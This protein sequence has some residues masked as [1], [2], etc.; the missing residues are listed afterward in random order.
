MRTEYSLTILSSPPVPISAV[1]AVIT[2]PPKV[3]NSL[4]QPRIGITVRENNDVSN[5]E[6]RYDGCDDD[7]GS[8][9]ICCATRP[10]FDTPKEHV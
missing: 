5:S 1:L 8:T 10:T 7:G 6:K 4:N 3:G 9:L 2:V